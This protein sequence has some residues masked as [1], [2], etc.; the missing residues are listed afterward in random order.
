[1]WASV[2]DGVVAW[3]AMPDTG[4]FKTGVF[5]TTLA[6]DGADPM[7]VTGSAGTLESVS[8]TTEG[9]MWLG[10]GTLGLQ[11]MTFGSGE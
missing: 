11:V 5:A 10:A 4:E 6:D 1:M 9:V 8:L 2:L 7:M 3:I